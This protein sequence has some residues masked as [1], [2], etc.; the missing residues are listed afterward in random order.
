MWIAVLPSSLVAAEPLLGGT[1]LNNFV[2]KIDPKAG[3][4]HLAVIAGNSKVTTAGGA[5]D[6]KDSKKPTG[7]AASEKMEK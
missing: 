7:K 3:E 4:L 1:F 2:F 6:P 5:K